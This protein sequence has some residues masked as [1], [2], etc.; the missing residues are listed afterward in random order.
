MSSFKLGFQVL[1]L[2]TTLALSSGCVSG[3]KVH[4]TPEAATTTVRLARADA[5]PLQ[6]HFEQVDR[7]I[8]GRIDFTADCS[9]ETRQVVHQERRRQRVSAG[10]IVEGAFGVAAMMGGFYALSESSSASSEVTCGT[11]GSPR[12]GDKCSSPAG[13]WREAGATLLATGAAMTAWGAVMAAQ[14][15]HTERQPLPDLQTVQVRPSQ[16]CGNVAALE[17]MSVAVLLPRFGGKWAGR[18]NADGSARIELP[19]KR[20]LPQGA[21]VSVF[22]DSVP[23]TLSTL[24]MPGSELAHITLN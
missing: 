8:V 6:A 16:P 15:K 24:V 23:E 2:G 10:W 14:S 9:S 13:T 18:V 21:T 7:A 11:G 1:G 19:A 20:A 22:V 3:M 17:G 5:V 4:R 12:D